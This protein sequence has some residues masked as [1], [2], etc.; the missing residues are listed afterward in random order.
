MEA[1]EAARSYE[2]KARCLALL[3]RFGGGRHRL[4]EVHPEGVGRYAGRHG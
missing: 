3:N 1:T 2:E 4:E